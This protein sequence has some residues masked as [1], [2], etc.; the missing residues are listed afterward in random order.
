MYC[1]KDLRLYT[2]L[3]MFALAKIFFMQLVVADSRWENNVL[4]ADKQ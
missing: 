2:Y 3:D 4:L 1:K